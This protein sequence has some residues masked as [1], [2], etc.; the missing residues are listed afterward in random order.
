MWCPQQFHFEDIHSRVEK[1][2]RVLVVEA[3]EQGRKE[4]VKI[5][6]GFTRT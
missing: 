3:T 6:K 4:C 1:F 5:I 2:I